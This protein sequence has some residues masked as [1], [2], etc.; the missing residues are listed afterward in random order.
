MKLIEPHRFG[1]VY[2]D[3]NGSR[4][5]AGLAEFTS[6]DARN[7]FYKARKKSNF[8][9]KADSTK[10]KDNVLKYP[11]EKIRSDPGVSKFI[12]YVYVD[13]NCNLMAFTLTGRFTKFNSEWEFD[14]LVSHVD[15][16]TTVSENIHD[17]IGNQLITLHPGE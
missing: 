6:W 1:E 9:V 3:R 5:Q 7:R 15:N 8:Y 10:Q 17:I 16:T 2:T 4:L 13:P 12:E 11:R 14:Y